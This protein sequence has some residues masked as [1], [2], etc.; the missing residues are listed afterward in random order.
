MLPLAKLRTLSDRPCRL[1][2]YAVFTRLYTVPLLTFTPN[3]VDWVFF[4]HVR[5]R[6]K[7]FILPTWEPTAAGSDSCSLTIT[8]II[9]PPPCI[10]LTVAGDKHLQKRLVESRHR[11]TPRHMLTLISS[12]ERGCCCSHYSGSGQSKK[13]STPVNDPP[14]P[15]RPGSGGLSC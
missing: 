12:G 4:H 2:D 11:L 8:R 13:V 10:T 1:T 15:A 5:V 14:S 9:S 7:S 3:N 6:G